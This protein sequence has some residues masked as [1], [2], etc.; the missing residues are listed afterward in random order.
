MKTQIQEHTH[1]LRLHKYPNGTKVYF[2]VLNCSYKVEVAF[3]LGK[4]TLCNI[5]NSE[6]EITK[7]TLR[8]QEPHCSDCGRVLVKNADGSR[9]Y[10]RKVANKVL[11]DV[12]NKTVENLSTRLASITS[13]S[14]IGDTQEDL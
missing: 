7:L 10:I 1:K 14:T 9:T 6:F 5:C 2:C 12:A 8:L 4:V 3:A 11:G 13:N